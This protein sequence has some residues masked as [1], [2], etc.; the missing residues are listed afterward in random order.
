[1]MFP[2]TAH[3]LTIKGRKLSGAAN[4]RIDGVDVELGKRQQEVKK[5]ADD[6]SATPEFYKSLKLE[7]M[8]PETSWQ[9]QGDH[10]L[11]ITNPDGQSAEAKFKI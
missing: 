8:R 7:I 5:D 3:T 11:V 4:F 10:T 6:Q 1:M 2:A 9:K